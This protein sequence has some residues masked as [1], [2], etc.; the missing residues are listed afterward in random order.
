[1]LPCLLAGCDS[2][3]APV[4]TEPPRPAGFPVASIHVAG[5]TELTEHAK[6]KDSQTLR[7]FVELMDTY[8]SKIKAPVTL[9]FELYRYVPHR[10]DPRGSRLRSWPDFDLFSQAG[11]HLYWRDYLRAYEFSLDVSPALP[12]E[13][14]YLVE[15]TCM[16]ADQRRIN[17]FYVLNSK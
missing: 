13:E 6:A 12:P 4:V 7:V 5:L 15:V 1:M 2:G 8:G 16:T 3:S 11:N 9:R 10:T 14:S 17:T